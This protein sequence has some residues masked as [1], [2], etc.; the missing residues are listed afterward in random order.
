MSWAG[1]VTGYCF[2]VR[3]GVF[4]SVPAPAHHRPFL[5]CCGGLQWRLWGWF[6]AFEGHGL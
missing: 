5:G 2:G 1:G 6:A 3:V 4:Q